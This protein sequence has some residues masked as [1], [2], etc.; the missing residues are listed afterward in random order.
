MIGFIRSFKRDKRGAS[1]VEFALAAPI[2]FMFIFGILQFGLVM[3]A[4]NSM[5]ASVG[6][7]SRSVALSFVN[8]TTA[9]YTTAQIKTLVENKAAAAPYY[10]DSTKMG[11]EVLKATT[12]SYAG[13]NEYTV[14]FGY[15]VPVVVPFLTFNVFTINVS[16]KVFTKAL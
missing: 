16:R 10:L 3:Q 4:R 8:A 6:D 12:T 1:A 2:L 11:V 5:I 7:V 15:N 13:T 9:P 14:A